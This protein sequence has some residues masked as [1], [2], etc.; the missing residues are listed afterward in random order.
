MIGNVAQAMEFNR[1]AALY[2]RDEPEWTAR[3][4]SQE[5]RIRNK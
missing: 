3:T 4:R 2:L 1:L 5:E